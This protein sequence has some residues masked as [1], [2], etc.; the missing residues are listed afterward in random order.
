[1]AAP[2]ELIAILMEEIANNTEIEHFQANIEVATGVTAAAQLLSNATAPVRVQSYVE[3]VV[4]LYSDMEF[5]SHFRMQRSTFEALCREVAPSMQ[6]E[7]SM[8]VNTRLLATIWM[9]SN[10]ECYRSVADR[11]GI[12]KGTLHLTVIQ[13]CQTL[14]NLKDKYIKFPE[15]RREMLSLA[16]GFR[17]RC[18]FPGVVGAVDGTHIPI[19]APISEFRAS[20]I[21][22]KGLSSMQL[23]VVCDSNLRFLDTYTGWP[24]SVHA[25]MGTARFSN[26]LKNCQTNS[27]S[28]GILPIHCLHTFLLH[29]E[30][31]AI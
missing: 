21:N 8:T 12:S 11:F 16:E 4:D 22:R 18:G 6:R 25:C 2:R 20:F 15:A 7:R 9:L 10:K 1:M 31:M 19:P 30:T 13:T 28:L 26:L 24:G 29:T 3:D 17:V 14:S 23:Q 27:M 5:K